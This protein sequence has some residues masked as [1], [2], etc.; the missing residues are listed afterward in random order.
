MHAPL[1]TRRGSTGFELRG[2]SSAHLDFSGDLNEDCDDDCD[3]DCDGN[4]DEVTAHGS[5]ATLP[6]E[7]GYRVIESRFGTVPSGGSFKIA[8]NAPT[9]LTASTNSGNLT[10]LTT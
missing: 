8:Q 3:D 7:S 5:E 1:G 2:E 9:C 10:G 4:C 6:G